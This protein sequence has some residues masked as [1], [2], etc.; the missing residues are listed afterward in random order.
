LRKALFQDNCKKSGVEFDP[1]MSR[2]PLDVS[3]EIIQVTKNAT[4][5]GESAVAE[6]VLPFMITDLMS[7]RSMYS[8]SVDIF[9]INRLLAKSIVNLVFT[10]TLTKTANNIFQ[11]TDSYM[12]ILDNISYALNLNPEDAEDLDE[13]KILKSMINY[14]AND[15]EYSNLSI[16]P[17]IPEIKTSRPLSQA[18]RTAIVANALLTKRGIISKNDGIYQFKLDIENSKKLI[19]KGVFTDGDTARIY[20][21][22]SRADFP[23]GQNS[24]KTWLD[25]AKGSYFL[26][27]KDGHKKASVKAIIMR[28][29]ILNL[30]N[31]ADLNTQEILKKVL[32]AM[33][34]LSNSG[35][36]RLK[37]QIITK[38]MYHPNFEL[39]NFSGY[40]VN[41]YQV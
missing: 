35:Y 25:N 24:W 26:S 4:M 36:V 5:L 19:E 30:I 11:A 10:L 20:E 8:K 40:L 2:Y 12:S 34:F 9:E 38:L 29:E 15:L 18:L 31:E 21:G 13:A 23:L 14:V 32:D 7:I 16:R 33:I 28:T 41:Q 39:R 27:V 1:L 6:S 22:I 17:L 3:R 37:N